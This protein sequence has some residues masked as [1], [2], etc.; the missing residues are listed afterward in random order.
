MF[1]FGWVT[2]SKI[3]RNIKVNNILTRVIKEYLSEIGFEHYKFENKSR[4][5]QAL[6][7]NKICYIFIWRDHCL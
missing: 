5:H 3:T 4:F 1:S 2:Q 7:S 6:P